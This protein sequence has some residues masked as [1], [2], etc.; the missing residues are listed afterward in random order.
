MS[1]HG[2][3]DSR[4]VAERSGSGGHGAPE[5]LSL[6]L[7]APRLNPGARI[8]ENLFFAV[9]PDPD[10]KA[11]IAALVAA[12]ER[13]RR[14]AGR[15]VAPACLHVSLQSLGAHAQ[16]RPDIIAAGR[17]AGAAIAQSPFGVT[18]DRVLGFN[19]RGGFAI[20]LAA[21]NELRGL[22]E[23]HQ[24]LGVQ[25]EH[26]GLGHYRRPMPTPHVTLFYARQDV[27]KIDIRPVAWTVGE[28]VLVQSLYGQGRHVHLGRWKLRG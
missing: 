9:L 14:L 4:P 19:A 2:M 1:R 18:F 15:P 17:R 7:A 25:M 11:Q 26:A 13:E 12:L 28:L 3:F 5:Q 16:A 8:G 27:A 10:A 20:V 21:A 22:K 23:L 24:A 6:A